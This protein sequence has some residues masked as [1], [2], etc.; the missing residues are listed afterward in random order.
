MGYDFNVGD[1]V[2]FIPKDGMPRLVT[3]VKKEKFIEDWYYDE[4]VYVYDVKDDNGYSHHVG[5]G[6]TIIS[7]NSY[8]ECLRSYLGVH[9]RK[10]ELLKEQLNNERVVINEANKALNKIG[11]KCLK[12]VVW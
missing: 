9:E 2:T 10:L 11:S 8:D 12:E 4:D 7:V 6:D 3:I 5:C 1:R